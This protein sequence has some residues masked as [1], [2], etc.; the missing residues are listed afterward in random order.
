MVF[1]R[2]WRTLQA[3]GSAEEACRPFLVHCAVV[4]WPKSRLEGGATTTH[5]PT[6]AEMA[7]RWGRDE[8]E[9]KKK[10]KEGEKSL[11]TDDGGA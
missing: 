7:D 1:R 8:R 11:E 2:E 9:K 4:F 3:T 10:K 5:T 6:V